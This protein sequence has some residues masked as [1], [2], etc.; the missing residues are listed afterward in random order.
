M[1]WRHGDWYGWEQIFPG[2]SL[3]KAPRPQTPAP[4]GFFPSRSHHSHK[5]IFLPVENTRTYNSADVPHQSLSA[6]YFQS[7]PAGPPTDDEN[8]AILFLV[9]R[10]R[11]GHKGYLFSKQDHMLPATPFRMKMGIFGTVVTVAIG[12]AIRVGAGHDGRLLPAFDN[13]LLEFTSGHRH[14]VPSQFHPAFRGPH[15]V[16]FRPPRIATWPSPSRYL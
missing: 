6:G 15:P 11:P 13:S 10:R 5:S 8:E 2:P 4:R 12:K 1:T 3:S 9:F 16:I 14:W 7:S